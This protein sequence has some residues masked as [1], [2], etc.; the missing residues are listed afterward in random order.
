MKE[1]KCNHRIK[2]NALFGDRKF[3]ELRATKG[4]FEYIAHNGNPQ[5]V[6]LE[7]CTECGQVLVK[8]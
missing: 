8:L 2:E 6:K 5:P 7:F 4:H 3:I 1:N